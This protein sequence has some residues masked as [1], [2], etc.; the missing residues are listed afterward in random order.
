MRAI[1]GGL[2]SSESASYGAAA[3]QRGPRRQEG[4]NPMSEIIP[5]CAVPL[6]H[7][8]LAKGIWGRGKTGLKCVLKPRRGRISLPLT[9][10]SLLSLPSPQPLTGEREQGETE[11]YG[12]PW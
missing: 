4:C 7:A 5:G 9:L 10:L 12:Q 11:G 2:H 1:R 6:V 8:G 3:A